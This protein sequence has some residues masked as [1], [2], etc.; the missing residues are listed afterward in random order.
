MFT[1]YPLR[2]ALL[3]ACLLACLVEAAPLVTISGQTHGENVSW[4]RETSAVRT[5]VYLTNHEPYAVICDAEMKTSYEEKLEK[6]EITIPA[7]KTASFDFRHNKSVTNL[8]VFLV[9]EANKAE[10][11]KMEEQGQTGDARIEKTTG[12]IVTHK[13][14]P[15]APKTHKVEVEDLGHF[16]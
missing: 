16:D 14:E 6:P 10:K 13:L 1:R 9:C 5:T 12:D 7:G 15:E 4:H 3:P 11:A 8:Q 2:F